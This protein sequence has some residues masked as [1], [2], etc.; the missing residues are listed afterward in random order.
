MTCAKPVTLTVEAT[1]PKSCSMAIGVTVNHGGSCS[2]PFNLVVEETGVFLNEP[3]TFYEYCEGGADLGVAACV[4]VNAGV[5]SSESSLAD[6]NQQARYAA[7]LVVGNAGPCCA[8]DPTPATT[9]ENIVWSIV[10]AGTPGGGAGNTFTFDNPT[11]TGTGFVTLAPGGDGSTT[12]SSVTYTAVWCNPWPAYDLEVTIN[13]AASGVGSNESFRI[14]VGTDDGSLGDIAT[15]S[16]AIGNTDPVVAYAS[17]LDHKAVILRTGSGAVATSGSFVLTIP[18]TLLGQNKLIILLAVAKLVGTS[19]PTI[20]LTTSSITVRPLVPPVTSQEC[21]AITEV[22]DP[23][24]YSDRP[25]N[26]DFSDAETIAGASGTIVGNTSYASKEFGEPSAS[27]SIWYKW[28]APASGEASFDTVGS[29]N[30]VALAIFTGPDLDNLTS[31]AE[32]ND[33]PST[34]TF[35]AVN[36]TTYWIRLDSADGDEGATTLNWPTS[37]GPPANDNFA[38]AEL[39]SGASGTLNATNALATVEI[40]EPATIDGSNASTSIWYKWVAPASGTKEFNTVGSDFDTLLAIYTGTSVGA[41]T[42]IGEDDDSGGSGTSRVTIAVT[43][44][45]TYRIRVDGYGGDTGNVVLNWA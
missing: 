31:I 41:L 34:A 1:G 12:S 29:A 39:I 3:L 18:I 8:G 37:I 43:M 15:T 22:P 38:D 13:W 33:S 26:D 28:I 30:D 5:F 9:V 25:A 4:S 10:P 14:Y 19:G 21:V 6:A 44:G 7:S 36:G 23:F 24:H 40:G 35:T 45:T 17:G 20:T 27:H 32:N 2:K 42:T 16:P 11:A